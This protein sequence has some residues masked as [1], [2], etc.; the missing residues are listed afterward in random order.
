MIITAD[1]S[2]INRVRITN[3]LNQ[4][5]GALNSQA[6]IFASINAIGSLDEFISLCSDIS[7]GFSEYITL[8]SPTD[9]VINAFVT[10]GSAAANVDGNY[11]KQ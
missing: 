6:E 7:F 2:N 1:P 11:V 4:H 8:I 9:L 5:C 3:I 10:N